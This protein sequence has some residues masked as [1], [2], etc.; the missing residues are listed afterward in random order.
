MRRFAGLGLLLFAAPLSAQTIRDYEYSRP[1][2]GEKQLRAV[3]E[4]AAGRLAVRRGPADRLY[5][6]T[7]QYDAQRFR[8]IGR[9]DAGASEVR[10]GVEGTG[11]GGLRVDRR[12]ALPQVAVVELPASVDLALDV[13]IGAADGTLDLGGLRLSALQ[14]RTG[15]SRTAL[16][17]DT[18][19]TGGCRTASVTSGAGEVTVSNVGNSGCRSWRFDGG[20]GK[21]NLDLS[22]AWPADAR[23]T[24]NLALGGVTLS[25]P[26]DL[27]LR[28]TL[29][30][31]LSGF[32]ATGFSKEGKTYTST[33]YRTARR[34]LE[35]EVSSAL[36]GVSVVWR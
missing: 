34:H 5:G 11:S 28:I 14:I 8:P 26:R 32:D 31:F 27:G 25:A 16:S 24:L 7:L 9:Y 21:V 23:M 1:L 15:A 4:F 30:G 20:V 29:S 2:R 17:F 13:S 12:S 33:N 18:P 36:G 22:G 3:V 19:A 10:L 6:L 35:V